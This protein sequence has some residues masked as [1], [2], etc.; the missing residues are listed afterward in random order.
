MLIVNAHGHQITKLKTVYGI[1]AKIK[2]RQNKALY[3]MSCNKV[4]AILV[5]H[6]QEK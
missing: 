4:V 6:K 5:V 1:I 2:R 3:D